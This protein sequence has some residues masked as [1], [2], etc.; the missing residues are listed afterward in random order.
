MNQKH[1]HR[2]LLLLFLVSLVINLIQFCGGSYYYCS[3]L[4]TGTYIEAEAPRL[5]RKML[6]LTDGTF[7]YY[8]IEKETPLAQ[9]SYEIKGR[10]MCVFYDESGNVSGC[11]VLKRRALLYVLWN[12]GSNVV[13]NKYDPVAVLP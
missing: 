13:F 4:T 2:I 7:F 8:T 12:D 9:G 11:G 10:D 1:Q 3:N 5:T 6:A